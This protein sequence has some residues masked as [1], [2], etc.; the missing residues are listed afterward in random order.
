MKRLLLA[1]ALTLAAPLGFAAGAPALTVYK[2]PTC[3]CCTG[4][5]D[6]MK[7]E[8]FPVKV[9]DLQDVTPIKRRHG[10]PEALASCHTAVV[11]GTGQVIEGHVPAN[12]VRKMLA[13]KSVKGVAVPGMPANSPGMGP[14]DGKLV[15]YDFKARPYSRD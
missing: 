2:S 7:R 12:V 13:D 6:Y 11:D 5:I 15:T 8:G 1:I 10:V 3:G 9:V 4:W 14:Q